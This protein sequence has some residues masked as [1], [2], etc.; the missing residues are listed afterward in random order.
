MEDALES[1]KKV[2]RGALRVLGG[3]AAGQ[4]ISEKGGM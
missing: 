2:S 3:G 1:R 4:G